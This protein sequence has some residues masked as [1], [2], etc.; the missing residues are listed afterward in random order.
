MVLAAHGTNVREAELEAH[1]KIETGGTPIDELERLARSYGLVAEIQDITVDGLQRIL[2]A[3]KQAIAYIDR[4][5]FNLS[6]AERR[7]HSIR[8]AIIHNVIPANIT[9]RSVT[10]HDPRFPRSHAGAQA[11]FDGRTKAWEDNRS[12]VPAREH[13]GN[14]LAPH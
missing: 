7:R 11:S 3:G 2:A 5:I 9:E 14:T 10:L 13:L 8:D 6:A 4:A 12:S 1:A